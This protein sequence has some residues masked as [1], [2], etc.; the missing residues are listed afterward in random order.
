MGFQVISSNNDVEAEVSPGGRPMEVVGQV[1]SSASSTEEYTQGVCSTQGEP[2]GEA[3]LAEF[4]SS[5]PGVHLYNQ[6]RWV[7]FPPPRSCSTVEEYFRRL[8][9]RRFSL[10]ASPE[11][12]STGVSMLV[13]RPPVLGFSAEA[14]KR[15]AEKNN[16]NL[17][18]KPLNPKSKISKPQTKPPKP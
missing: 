5:V 12:F 14:D 18:T 17:N 2:V 15:G 7:P 9:L 10:R 13:Y 16:P 11:C 8:R 3:D 1:S 6:G 4:L